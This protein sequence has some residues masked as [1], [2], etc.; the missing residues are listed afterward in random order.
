MKNYYNTNKYIKI[1]ILIN[2]KTFFTKIIII[3]KKNSFLKYRKMKTNTHELLIYV[4]WGSYT[5]SI[6]LKPLLILKH[7]Y[8]LG[9]IYRGRTL[10]KG[11]QLLFRGST[12]LP[13]TG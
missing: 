4:Y 1:D 13:R 12:P 3:I 9:A 8:I 10:S 6:P 7:P 5:P 11:L 2:C